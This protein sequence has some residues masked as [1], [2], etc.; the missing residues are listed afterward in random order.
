MSDKNT[1]KK[2]AELREILR[3]L[4]SALVCFSG[5]VDSTFLLKAALDELGPK[6][7]VA[8]LVKSALYPA[9]VL[10]EARCVGDSLGARVVE[11]DLDILLVQGIK[12]NPP[13]R[14]YHC[15]REILEAALSRARTLGLDHVIEGAIVDDLTDYR[16]GRKAVEE[17]GV[18]SPLLEA[19]L[20]KEEIRAA[21]KALDL[22][23]WDKTSYPCLAT[24][25]PHGVTIE[26][27]KIER[28]A[29]CEEDIRNEGFKVFRVRYHGNLARIEL[30]PGEFPRLFSGGRRKKVVAACKKAGFRYVAMDL[31]GYR[32]GSMNHVDVSGGVLSKK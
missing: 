20:T 19:G 6:K 26:A 29:R 15:K 28:V 21:S 24:R 8:L 2:V 16:P 11:L 25:F 12:D 5:G 22:P 13:D 10:S 9:A 7:A 27:E 14:C 3:S 17:L 32:T 1:D 23:T 4:G 30:A 18:R 31:E